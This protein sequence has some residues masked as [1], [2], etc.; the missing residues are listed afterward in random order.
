MLHCKLNL[1]HNSC[2]ARIIWLFLVLYLSLVSGVGSAQTTKHVLV[3]YDISQSMRGHWDREEIERINGYLSRLLFDGLSDISHQ[4]KIISIKETPL[5]EKGVPLLNSG[6]RLSFLKF[7]PPPIPSPQ[8]SN[9]YD[10][11]SSLRR[12]LAISLPKTRGELTEDWTCLELFHWKAGQIFGEYPGLKPYLIVLISDKCE[13]RYPLSLEDQRRILHHKGKYR[14]DLLLDIQVGVVH[15]EVCELIPPA[16]GIDILKPKPWEVYFAGKPLLISIQMIKEGEVLREEGWKVVASVVSKDRPKEKK[17]IILNDKGFGPDEQADDGIHTGT[18]LGHKSGPVDILIRASKGPL[19]FQSDELHLM[20]SSPAG[21][22]IW[23]IIILLLFIG[24][25]FWHWF[26]PLRFWIEREGAGT[27]PRRL[28]LK[29]IGEVLFLGKR[30]D[31]PYVDLGLP[32]YSI[33]RQKRKEIV[34]WQQGKEEGEVAPW[35]T[36]F[37]PSGQEEVV[38]RFSLKKLRHEEVRQDREIKSQK[39]EEEDFYKW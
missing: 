22:P 36:W 10:G 12:E 3:G 31:E 19:E 18:F 2:F 8:L 28:K 39:V 6:D 38:L 13:S 16:S 14:K 30:E 21:P 9:V 25:A 17:D 23:F 20:L 15:L 29:G 34:I 5:F 32:Q 4:D 33:L 27:P 1:I 37:S 35:N 11:S 26:W 24:L 7:G